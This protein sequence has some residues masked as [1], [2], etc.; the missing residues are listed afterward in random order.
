VQRPWDG[1]AAVDATLLARPD[2]PSSAQHAS[3]RRKG[4]SHPRSTR[5]RH[6]PS[7][8]GRDEVHDND[9]R[10]P[11]R[12]DTALRGAAPLSPLP[13]SSCTRSHARQ[14]AGHPKPAATPAAKHAAA[15]GAGQHEAPLQ[16]AAPHRQR[17]AAAETTVEDGRDMPGQRGSCVSGSVAASA[18]E[19]E[20]LEL[21][22]VAVRRLRGLRLC[23]DGHEEAR[24]THLVLG[25]PRRTLK[26]HPE[27]LDGS[28][29]LC[30]CSLSCACTE[31]RCSGMPAKTC[32]PP[33][34][35]VTGDQIAASELRFASAH[36]HRSPWLG[37][38][39]Q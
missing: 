37:H 11:G 30:R 34:A 6:A 1:R 8:L 27:P 2:A 22:R 32:F 19:A 16:Q 36:I 15:G 23:E 20:V 14:N 12:E 18:V 24:L 7:S 38:I 4:V 33:P 29:M 3:T 28:K 25:T 21:L 17:A 5:Q 35:R 26:V 9:E 10:S 31:R 13:P 39:T